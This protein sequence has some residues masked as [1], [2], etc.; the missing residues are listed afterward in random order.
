M[1]ANIPTYEMRLP[2]TLQAALGLLNEGWLPFAGGTDLM[3]QLEAGRLTHHRF[4]SLSRL[5]ELRTIDASLQSVTVGACT[6]FA[7]IRRSP[8]LQAEFPLLV[9]AAAEIGGPANQNR[10]T[11]GGNIANASPA[12]DAA[13]ALLVYDAELEIAACG[14]SR[15]IPYHQFHC[16]YKKFDLSPGELITR[17]HLPRGK[18]GWQHY[19]RKVAPRASQAITKVSLAAAARLSHGVIA[20]IRIAGGAVAPFP[21]RC[22][23]TEDTLRGSSLSH[24]PKLPDET[25][26]IDDLRSTATYRRTVFGNLLR[27]FLESLA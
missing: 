2:H 14:S 21:L 24:I 4:S 16:D 6:T 22:F 25:V 18:D 17:I 15:L 27:Q 12:A 10:A 9:Q 20:D 23:R 8:L 19:W 7:E 13:P 3:V 26:P 11:L 1:R 5:A